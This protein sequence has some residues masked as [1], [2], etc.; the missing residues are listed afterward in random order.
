MKFLKKSIICYTNEKYHFNNVA[1]FIFPELSKWKLF[2]QQTYYSIISRTHSI[3][4]YGSR[5]SGA[6]QGKK[7]YPPLHLSVVAIKKESL[8]VSL[9]T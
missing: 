8:Q 2:R 3:I 6:I 5:V 9:L 1:C 4:R 7:S